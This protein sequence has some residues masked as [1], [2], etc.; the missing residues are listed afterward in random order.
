MV[1]DADLAHRTTAGAFL[2]TGTDP[3]RFRDLPS[4][5]PEVLAARAATPDAEFVIGPDFRLTFGEADERS[6]RLAGQLLA[7]GVGKGSR[8]GILFP[9]GPA[10]VVTWLASARIGALTVPLSTFSPGPELA[11]TIRHTDLAALLMGSSFVDTDLS[12]RLEEGLPG[13]SVSSSA[14]ALTGA[15][16]LRWVNV[17]G[18]V[19]PVWSRGLPRPVD[20]EV[21]AAAQSEVR[22]S[23][24]LIMINTSGSTADP[25]TVVHTHGGLIRHAAM[26]VRLR[27]IGP[28]D[29]L[30]CP[31]PFFWV[32]GLTTLLL[33]ALTC[34]ASVLV[35]ER[36]EPAQA[37]D[38]MERERATLVQVWPNASRAMAEHPTF[39]QR[40]LT[41]IRGGTL[42]EALPE[43][44]RP[45]SP[46]LYPGLFGMTE[47][48]GP[49]SNPDDPYTPLPEHLRGT[50]GRAIPGVER[51]IIDPATGDRVSTGVVGQ[52]F[53]RG[54]FV[55]EQLYKVERWK[56][57]TPDG[58]YPT[59]D[60]CSLDDE[61]H[62][63]FHG[64]ATSMIKTGGSNV[65]PTE[66]EDVLLGADGV[67]MVYVFGVTSGLR[68][69]DVV[70]V[71][72]RSEGNVLTVE[73]LVAY[74]RQHLSTFKIPRRWAMLDPSTVPVLP[75]GKV[76]QQALRSLF[77]EQ[78]GSH[79]GLT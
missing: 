73:E 18:E 42:P 16:F 46:D 5:I 52:L 43:A 30:Y 63:R 72:V 69:E 51:M 48:G 17:F 75:T 26:L 41:S 13:L 31:M 78:P 33:S 61:G 45:P 19:H 39:D 77:E 15:P 76:D 36:F 7:A 28:Q 29:R 8:V 20:P 21:V 38:L 67:E 10:W 47:T 79:S 50:L 68:G 71:V 11:R 9:N 66:V 58:W 3:A 40:D 55:M 24:G 57:F 70:A 49:H 27:Q 32:G 74:A 12:A 2:G 54:P 53:V 56:T 44:L 64:R 65:A 59:G 35:Q 23:D 6:A 1:Q 4:S 22:P 14:L 60:Q 37:L 34:G 62:L 25:K